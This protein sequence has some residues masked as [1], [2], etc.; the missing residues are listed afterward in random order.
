MT[1]QIQIDAMGATE[2]EQ[3]ITTRIEEKRRKHKTKLER[4]K[5]NYLSLLNPN[6]ISQSSSSSFYS[7][8]IDAHLL[9]KNKFKN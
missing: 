3:R 2:E 5:F 6:S 1:I 7:S 4:E 8:V 9:I